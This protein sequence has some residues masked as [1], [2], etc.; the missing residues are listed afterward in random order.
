MAKKHTLWIECGKEYVTLKSGA[1]MPKEYANSLYSA[2][3]G[4]AGV[5]RKEFERWSR[6]ELPKGGC[7]VGLEVQFSVIARKRVVKEEILVERALIR[8]K[9][10]DLH[11]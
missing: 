10:E 1:A 7:I 9:L 8:S 11:D 6:V 2:L 3:W 4:T 5:S